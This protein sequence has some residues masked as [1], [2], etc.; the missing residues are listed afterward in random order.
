MEE[1]IRE[2]VKNNQDRFEKNKNIIKEIQHSQ[3]DRNFWKSI[4]YIK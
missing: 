2:F 1:E 3:S 4:K